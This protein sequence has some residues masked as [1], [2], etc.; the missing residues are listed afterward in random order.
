MAIVLCVTIEAFESIFLIYSRF[1]LPML[2][3]QEQ[4]S[5]YSGERGHCFRQTQET[6][7]GLDL[8]DRCCSTYTNPRHGDTREVSVEYMMSLLYYRAPII[9]RLRKG[10]IRPIW[11]TDISRRLRLLQLMLPSILPR[12]S[13]EVRNW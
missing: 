1:A 8:I 13:S 12:I 3:F 4:E 2:Q 9:H 10:R 11:V 5:I 7:A 6:D